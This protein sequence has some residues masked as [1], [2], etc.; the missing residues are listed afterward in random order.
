MAF[1]WLSLCKGQQGVEGSGVVVVGGDIWSHQRHGNAGEI[2]SSEPQLLGF[3][4]IFFSP[5]E[6]E[7]M[8]GLLKLPYTP[9]TLRDLVEMQALTQRV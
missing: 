9:K 7:E 4:A 8:W 5:E 3:K 6:A 2:I 1:P